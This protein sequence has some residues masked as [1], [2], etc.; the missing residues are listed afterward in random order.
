M[1]EEQVNRNS[2]IVKIA[3]FVDSITDDDIKM[4]IEIIDDSTATNENNNYD[5][6]SSTYI[7]IP[8][9]YEPF[10]KIITNEANLNSYWI[11]ITYTYESG[12]YGIS[13]L[14]DVNIENII[15]SISKDT[16]NRI[17]KVCKNY[18]KDYIKTKYKE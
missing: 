4:Q 15:E 13:V 17:E 18:I 11:T 8:T 1:S 12:Y 6:Q 3:E 2:A 10:A 14:G 7:R 16:Y 5:I 9:N